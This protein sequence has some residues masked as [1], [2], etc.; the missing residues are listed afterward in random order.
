M[1]KHILVLSVLLLTG[2]C[3]TQPFIDTA[4]RPSPSVP[5]RDAL[6]AAD[7]ACSGPWKPWAMT[8]VHTTWPYRTYVSETMRCLNSARVV[9]PFTYRTDGL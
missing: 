4:S 7:A 2:A 6:N 8:V 1:T 3:A 5:D 9:G